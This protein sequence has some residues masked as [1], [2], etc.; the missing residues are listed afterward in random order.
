MTSTPILE[1]ENIRCSYEQQVII[2]EFFLTL[3]PGEI[4]CFLGPSGCGKTTLLRAIAG[5]EPIQ[6]GTITLDNQQVSAPNRITAP[7]KRQIGFI[8]QDYA[9]FPHLTVE[10]NIAFGLSKSPQQTIRD[11]V[12]EMLS[13]TD[14][15]GL[16]KRY[17]HELSGGQQQRVALARALAP[18]PKLLLLDEPFSNLDVELRRRLSAEIRDLLVDRGISAI[19][20]T[21]DQ[22]EAF[23]VADKIGVLHNGALCQW[24][25]PF[26]LYHQPSNRFV[27]NFVG[28]GHFITGLAVDAVSI[29]T[30]AGTFSSHIRYPWPAN[31][32]VEVLIRPDDVV[33][34]KDSALKAE[35]INKTFQGATTLYTLRLSSGEIFDALL[36]SHANYDLKQWIPIGL[37]I[38][39]IVAFEK[40]GQ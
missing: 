12:K 19:L 30:A 23:A 10:K 33:Y 16:S 26:N 40:Q 8:F 38:D 24:D 5:F 17:P 4:G 32:A 25:T 22:N 28:R 18:S 9:L 7:E 11:K 31:T 1:I 35:I 13:L 39:H 34:N 20:V 37:E 15:E 2:D 36:P 3:H 27:A 6:K 29:K 21:H 14:L